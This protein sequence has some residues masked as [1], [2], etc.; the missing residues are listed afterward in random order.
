MFAKDLCPQA[1]K[2]KKKNKEGNEK[3]RKM[4]KEGRPVIQ[5]KRRTGG[6]EKER[7]NNERARDV[8][9]NYEYIVPLDTIK[10]RL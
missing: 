3:M 8:Y 5:V 4:M 7:G 1:R 6:K 9:L 10:E 2:N